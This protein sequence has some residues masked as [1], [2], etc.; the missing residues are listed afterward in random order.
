[1]NC[2]VEYST[3]SGV[4]RA[5]RSNGVGC[6]QYVVHCFFNLSKFERR[7]TSS[8][9]ETRHVKMP[10]CEHSAAVCHF[11]R[12]RL[13][14]VLAGAHGYGM[15]GDH[16]GSHRSHNTSRKLKYHEY[17][18]RRSSFGGGTC[19]NRVGCRTSLSKANHHLLLRL[20]PLRCPQS[21][22]LAVTLGKTHLLCEA[23]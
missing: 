23:P 18:T 20:T 4:S 8:R 10:L 13:R 16:K 1:M 14:A 3:W 2:A 22:S 7:A 6:Q 19:A 9:C 5:I 17:I 12:G 11:R 21:C 15:S